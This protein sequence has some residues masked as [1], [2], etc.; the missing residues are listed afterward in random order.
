LYNWLDDAIPSLSDYQDILSHTNLLK[1]EDALSE[2]WHFDDEFDGNHVSLIGFSQ[3]I[4]GANSG[5]Q[6]KPFNP[7]S[8]F[9]LAIHHG[10]I[11][12][13]DNVYVT[14]LESNSKGVKIHYS[15][16]DSVFV[17][18]LYDSVFVA[19]GCINST[20]IVHRSVYPDI[21]AEY[22][23]KMT[24]GFVQ[25]FFGNGPSESEALNLRRENNLPEIFLEI[26]DEA[27]KGFW[28][29]TQIT[30]LNSHVIETTLPFL[31][32]TL[33]QYFRK[34]INM[35]YL[36]LSAVHSSLSPKMKLI[37]DRHSKNS[38]FG[39]ILL[40]EQTM[41]Y[42]QSQRMA[43]RKA[44]NTHKDY[45]NLTHLPYS[46]FLGNLL[47]RNRLGGWH[48]GGTLPVTE[49]DMNTITCKPNAEVRH[50]PK[51]F[52]C[53]SSTFN[54]IPATTVALLTMANATRIA[55]VWLENKGLT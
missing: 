31:P 37:V 23:V 36:A 48:F 2:R 7:G 9:D 28:S 8:F 45:L 21:A 24:G 47:R 33:H 44:V 55:R 20:G 15:S 35:F 53:D 49:Y 43:V 3:I 42:E 51:V 1:E 41:P 19:A 12:Y 14:S 6:L 39:S 27:F 29:N 16:L 22:S 4:T 11:N 40:E 5:Y 32:S 34:K 52:V 17:S 50:L 54:S 46:E 25:G 38:R 30:A 26:R 18:S 13:L 10:K